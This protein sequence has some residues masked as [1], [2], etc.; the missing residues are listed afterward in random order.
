[1][2][3]DAEL[4]EDV[5]VLKRQVESLVLNKPVNVADTYQ[6]DVCWLCTSP[7][8]FTQN[9]HTLS[10]RNPIEEVNAFNEYKKPTSGPFSKT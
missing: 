9:C 1:M 2:K 7:M 8:H 3:D 10:T 5:K 4:R 6:V